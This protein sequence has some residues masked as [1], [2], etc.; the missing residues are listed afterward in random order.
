[1][2][3]RE[4]LTRCQAGDALAWEALVRQFQGRVCAV[5]YSYT[6]DPEEARDLAQEIFVR[7]YRRLDTCRDP[8][9]F[10]AWMLRLA[11]NTAIDQ[12][13]A[14]QA[15]GAGSNVS[16]EEAAELAAGDPNPEET[17]EVEE[18]QQI[19]YRALH[20]LDEG[21][22][23]IILLKEVQGL[24]VEEVARVLEVPAGT[25]KSRSHRARIELARAILDVTGGAGLEATA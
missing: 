20:R 7:V 9:R 18:R 1:M 5:A 4:L 24:S 8:D 2:E 22:R 16:V 19:L 6:S 15:R 12:L 10:P 25:V 13:R 23:E 17:W 21:L 3:L 14:R 11:R